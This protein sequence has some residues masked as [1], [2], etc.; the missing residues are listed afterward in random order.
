MAISRNNGIIYF[1]DKKDA[2]NSD[3]FMIFFYKSIPSN[4]TFGN[5]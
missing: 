1:E 2:Y 5:Q 3:D 4:T